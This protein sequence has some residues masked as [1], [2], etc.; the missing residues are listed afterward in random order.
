MKIDNAGSEILIKHRRRSRREGWLWAWLHDS[1]WETLA[2][3]SEDFSEN[4]LIKENSGW[5]KKDGDVPKEVTPAQ[6]MLPIKETLKEISG[7]WKLKG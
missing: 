1:I 4:E 6:K 5:D 3:Q 2:M 7:H